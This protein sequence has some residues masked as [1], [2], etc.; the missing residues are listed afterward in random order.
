MNATPP[1][2]ATAAPAAPPAMKSTNGLTIQR[3]QKAQTPLTVCVTGQ[4]G[5]GK[6]YTSLLLAAGM[7]GTDVRPDGTPKI[8]AVDTENGSMSL[9]GQGTDGAWPVVPFDTVVIRPEY[10]VAKYIEA[11]RMAIDGGYSVVILDSL[12]HAWQG[13]GGILDQKGKLDAR[14]GNQYTNWRAVDPDFNRFRDM[15]LNTSI[16]LIATMRS[17]MDY[18]VDERGK[19]T[20]IGLA[21][22]MRDGMEYEFSVVFDLDLA[23]QASVS[24]HRTGKL[25]A[26]RGLFV[27]TIETGRELKAWQ[28]TG[29]TAPVVK[30]AAVA[31][32]KNG[33]ANGAP[34]VA[35]R[36][37]VKGLRT[38]HGLTLAEARVLAGQDPNTASTFESVEALLVFLRQQPAPE[39][40]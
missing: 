7:A 38:A 26:G 8:L 11:Y 36:D 34:T 33:A 1:P 9:Y 2:A 5:G 21:P 28:Q 40:M 10:T 23:H 3:A 25:Y 29:I 16:D 39:S 20:K 32:A 31:A 4:S 17:K 15:I 6:S 35:Q 30:P 37:E 22:V 19:P 14:G 24:K 18:T 13:V 27:P 12:T